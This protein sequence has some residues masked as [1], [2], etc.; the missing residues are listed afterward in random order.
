M[1]AMV[2]SPPAPPH[3]TISQHAAP[4]VNVVKPENIIVFTTIY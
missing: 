1:A 4:Q 3:T 2:P